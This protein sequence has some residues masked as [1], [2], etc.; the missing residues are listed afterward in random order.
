[1]PYHIN[2]QSTVQTSSNRIHSSPTLPSLST[3]DSKATPQSQEAHN[4]VHN[5]LAEFLAD[6]VDCSGI[7][8]NAIRM[9]YHVLKEKNSIEYINERLPIV[10][11]AVH[12]CCVRKLPYT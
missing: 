3:L 5:Y 4:V 9:L 6:R 1:M 8:R 11:V 12:F 2:H 7:A 10:V